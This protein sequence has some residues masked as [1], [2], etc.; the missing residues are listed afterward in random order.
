VSAAPQELQKRPLAL[1]P[2]AGHVSVALLVTKGAASRRDRMSVQNEPRNNK[3]P[4]G[5]REWW[6]NHEELLISGNCG[7][8]LRNQEDVFIKLSQK[9]PLSV[10]LRSG[11]VPAASDNRFIPIVTDPGSV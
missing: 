1:A 5:D 6:K 8:G 9:T 10:A 7:S 11:N 3:G 4:D 2:Q